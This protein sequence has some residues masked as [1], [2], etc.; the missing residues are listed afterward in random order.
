MKRYISVRVVNGSGRPVPHERVALY[1]SQSVGAGMLPE[2]YTT[3]DGLAEFEPDID[4]FA[5][6]S[7]YV[8]G[9]E[10]VKTVPIQAK[11]TVVI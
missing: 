9:I 1:V 2:K 8:N 6:L 5:Q 4:E 11:F 10:K 3:T 7:V